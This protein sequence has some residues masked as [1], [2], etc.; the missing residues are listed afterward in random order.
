MGLGGMGYMSQARR[1]VPLLGEAGMA[2]AGGL[3][4]AL[5]LLTL[6]WSPWWPLTA[7]L[8]LGGGFCF[9]MLHNTLQTLATQMAPQARGLGVSMFATALFFGQGIGVLLA[10]ALMERWSASLVL[11]GA[12][13]MMAGIGAT[14]R[15][16]LRRR[17]GALPM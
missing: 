9:F 4:M 3:G 7:A 12:A 2:I 8:M 11:S 15:W 14:V 5:A 16:Q 17:R 1:V 6:A 10:A 13:C